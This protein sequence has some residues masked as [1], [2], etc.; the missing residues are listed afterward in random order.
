[1]KRLEDDHGVLVGG[2]LFLK[3]QISVT[4]RLTHRKTDH[5][6]CETPARIPQ[7]Q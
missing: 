2:F 4:D 5:L 1:M 7:G 3:A 6:S